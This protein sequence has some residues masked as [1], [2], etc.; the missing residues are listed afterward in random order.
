MNIAKRAVLIA[1]VLVVA[2]LAAPLTALAAT[3]YF[4]ITISE[5][6]GNSYTQL[7]LIHTVANNT[8]ADN[9]FMRSDG[10][11]TRV[12]SGD[13]ALPHMVANDRTVF[14]FDSLGADH[15]AA[16]RYSMGNE[17]LS[18]FDVVPGWGG[19]V[20]T[21]DSV[22]L[23]LGNTFEI[24][25]KCYVVTAADNVGDDLAH[26]EGAFRSYVDSAGNITS[27]FYISGGSSS[28]DA[29]LSGRTVSRSS[30]SYSTAVNSDTGDV[31][32]IS[33]DKQVCGQDYDASTYTIY[34]APMFFDTSALPDSA[35]VTAATLK[36]WGIDDYSTANFDLNLYQG[37]PTCPH[38]PVVSG[39]YDKDNYD[40]QEGGSLNTSSWTTSGW[41][42]IT[43]NEDGRSWIDPTG[44]TKII[45]I[46][47]E[48]ILQSAPIGHEMVSWADHRDGTH[49]PELEVTYD[50]L[51]VT[52]TT[53]LSSG[54]YTITTAADG[55]DLKLYIDGVEQDSTA[56]GGSSVQ[57]NSNDW[58]FMS[59]C[60]PYMSYLKID[61]G[62]VQKLWYQPNDMIS[63]TTLP[64][65]SGNSNNAVITWGSN[66]AGVS[67]ESA[68]M[69][70]IASEMSGAEEEDGT[71]TPLSGD[72][73]E[74][75]GW[76][77]DAS[78]YDAIPGSEVINE[79]AG[80]GGIP[81]RLVWVPLMFLIAMAA[82]F[83]IY[84]KTKHLMAV[85]IASGIVLVFFS[86]IGMLDWWVI[87]IYGIVAFAMCISEKTYD[88]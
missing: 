24:E 63:G 17:A 83:G 72:P 15:S 55:T 22:G 49:P 4:D 2:L 87:L 73:V 77:V 20:T 25:Q 66:P 5:T 52:V 39:D 69:C 7:P 67:L 6:S 76:F 26:K 82:G 27:G 78:E 43:L 88:W 58:I 50:Y 47:Y 36:L 48:T 54:E 59:S 57:N 12:K 29:T 46:S 75:T 28:Y 14:V 85:A 64:D 62:G 45:M 18:S 1:V 60:M 35:I 79:L 53:T 56:L 40:L 42:S 74:P 16:V 23:E 3:A 11:D 44:D 13:T 9:E 33:G 65:R 34:K 21:S 84:S 8:L 38:D 80:V 86:A 37:L 41:N 51:G 30:G 31:S 68:E 81:L 70:I 61:I 10:L 71:F 19:Y 32:D